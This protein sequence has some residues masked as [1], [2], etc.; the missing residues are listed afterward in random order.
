MN[1]D[2]WSGSLKQVHE[3]YEALVTGN[4]EYNSQREGWSSRGVQWQRIELLASDPN[5]RSLGNVLDVGCGRGEFAK[6]ITG[7]R[8][9]TGVDFVE[10]HITYAKSYFPNTTHRFHHAEAGGWLEE[11]SQKWDTVVASGLLAHHT[12]K[13]VRQLLAL[14]WYVTD[15]DGYMAFNINRATTSLRINDI[16]TILRDIGVDH[17]IIRHDYDVYD[18]TVYCYPTTTSDEGIDT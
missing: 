8:T 18:S 10:D 6:S 9:Y 13:T 1:T 11:Q 15:A 14:M 7:Y 2:K 3:D 4:A 5:F 16:F 12:P 17:Y